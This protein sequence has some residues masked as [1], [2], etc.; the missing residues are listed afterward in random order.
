MYAIVDFKGM[1]FK[2]EKDKV[3]KVPFLKD[4]E[5]G[6]SISLDSVIFYKD[7]KD[8]LL[9]MPNVENTKVEIEVL[10]HKKDKKI[11]VFKKKRRKGYQRKQG[12]RQ[13]FTEI[14]VKDIVRS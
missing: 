10:A 7:D 3:V 8:V 14:K 5:V 12:H 6:S 9:G 11:I 4:A 2:A 1:Q 13:D